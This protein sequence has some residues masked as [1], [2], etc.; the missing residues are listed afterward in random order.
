M[1]AWADM[2]VLKQCDYLRRNS[3]P[4]NGVSELFCCIK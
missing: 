3:A 1:G 2:G 4:I